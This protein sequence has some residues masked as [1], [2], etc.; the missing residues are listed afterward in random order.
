MLDELLR[1]DRRAPAVW[2]LVRYARGSFSL[3]PAS[4]KISRAHGYAE[5]PDSAPLARPPGGA[6]APASAPLAALAGGALARRFCSWT[7]KSGERY[8]CSVFPLDTCPSFVD[9]ILLAVRCLPDGG[10]EIVAAAETG[11][12]P[13]LLMDDPARL[14]VRSLGASE[15]HVHLLCETASARRAAIADVLRVG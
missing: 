8:V 5:D 12:A 15:W 3:S 14:Y 4:A 1:A 10:R 11:E 2:P 9:A 13:E 6:D 7:G